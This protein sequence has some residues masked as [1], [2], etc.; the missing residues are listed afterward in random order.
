MLRLFICLRIV[1]FVQLETSVAA[2]ERQSMNEQ[3]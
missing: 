1:S 2:K 3:S